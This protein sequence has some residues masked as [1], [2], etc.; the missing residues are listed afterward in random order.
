MERQRLGS[1]CDICLIQRDS[2]K[3]RMEKR[4]FGSNCDICSIQR[5]PRK[6]RNGKNDCLAQIVIFVQYKGIL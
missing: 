4:L 1:N 6:L 3:L 5:D 2:I